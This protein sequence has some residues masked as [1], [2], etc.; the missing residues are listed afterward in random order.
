M[1]RVEFEQ[2]PPQAVEVEQAVLGAMILDERGI[3]QAR[4]ILDQDS[5]FPGQNVF[6]HSAN[7]TIYKVAL[8][9][10]DRGEPVDQITIAE[11]LKAIDKLDGCGGVV[12]IS[13][14]ASEVATWANVRSH[15][16]IIWEKS[17]ARRLIET[18]IALTQRAYSGSEDIERLLQDSEEQLREIGIAQGKGGFRSYYDIMQDVLHNIEV[19]AQTPGVLRG[20]PSGFSELDNLTGGWQKSNLVILAGRPG[21]GKT[22]LAMALAKHAAKSGKIIGVNALEMADE[23]LGERDLSTTARIRT[24]DLRTGKLDPTDWTHATQRIH[25]LSGLTI[26]VDDQPGV[27]IAVARARARQLQRST[28]LDLLIVDYLQLMSAPSA[29]SREQEISAISRGLKHLAKELNIPVI[30]LSQLNRALEARQDH[31]PRLSDLRES[32][33]IEADADLVM[34]IHRPVTYGIKEIDGINVERLTQI[35]LKKQRNGPVGTFWLGW[36]PEYT[37][38]TDHLITGAEEAPRTW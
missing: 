33:S 26:Y 34:F 13:K 10:F 24:E 19:A 6:Y 27:N 2:I 8:A 32:G 30:A 37:T 21:E 1:S 4:A 38:F 18:T 12:Y 5:G 11:E 22:S 35:L 23:E 3:E 25:Q 20:I 9:L 28:G 14:L 16:R 31:T 36:E 15:A 17:L 29:Q 7:G